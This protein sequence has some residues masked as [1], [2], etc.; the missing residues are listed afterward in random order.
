MKKFLVFFVGLATLL[1]FAS[2]TNAADLRFKNKAEHN[3]NV[4]A[5]YETGPHGIVGESGVYH[6]GEDI[7]MRAGKSGNFQQWFYGESDETQGK[8]GDH[9]VW[10][11]KKDGK[12]CPDHFVLVE[13]ASENWGDYLKPGADYCVKTNDFHSNQ[14]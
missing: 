5:Y 9:S 14:K 11:V 2:I 8:E 6:E 12:D 13:N 1:T 3:P 4:V 7:V 10:L